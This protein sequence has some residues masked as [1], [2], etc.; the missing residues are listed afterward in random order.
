NTGT[1]NNCNGIFNNFGTITGNPINI[2]CI[3]MQD[4]TVSAGLSTHSGRQIQAEYVTGS[5]VLAG[6]QIDTIMVQLKKV[7][8]PTGNAT[9]GVFNTALSV[10]KS[11]A[12]ISVST[13]TTSYK[14]YTFSLPRLAQPYKIQPG[15]RIGIKFS[16]GNSTFYVAIMTDRTNAFDGTNSLHMYYDTAWKNLTTEDLYMTLKLTDR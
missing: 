13:L 6:K 5:S 12:S 2:S 14:D 7:G 10:K 11:F 8:L 1:I 3:F 16:G 9:V 15:D 4:T